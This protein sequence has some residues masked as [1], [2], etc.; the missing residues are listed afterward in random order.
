MIISVVMT[1]VRLSTKEKKMGIDKSKMNSEVTS[2]LCNV[3]VNAQELVEDLE[4]LQE[5]GLY[6]QQLK[7]QVRRT[8]QLCEEQVNRVFGVGF[9]KIQTAI[10]EGKSE[11]EIEE[12][13]KTV[14]I[15][16]AEMLKVYDM[17]VQSRNEY[18]A[19]DFNE[20]FL[21]LR[22]LQDIREGNVKYVGN[23]LYYR[24]QSTEELNRLQDDSK[25]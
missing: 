23:D 10:K 19:L 1:V 5:I 17:A 21:V 12:L 20:R 24:I 7:G 18:H 14:K 22:I 11:E 9:K 2:R 13:R 15:E 8:L 6:K 25:D 16:N 4:A 3:M